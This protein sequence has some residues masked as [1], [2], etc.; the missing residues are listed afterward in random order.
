MKESCENL[1]DQAY[2]FIIQKGMYID[3]L[4]WIEKRSVEGK[5]ATSAHSEC[6]TELE[7]ILGIALNINV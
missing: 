5:N 2:L 6:I 1:K 4:N 3:F 7:K